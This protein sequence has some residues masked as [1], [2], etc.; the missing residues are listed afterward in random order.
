MQKKHPGTRAWYA[1]KNPPPPELVSQ[2]E[3]ADESQLLYDQI[4]HDMEG[5]YVDIVKSVYNEMDT[6]KRNPSDF[7][8]WTPEDGNETFLKVIFDFAS[9]DLRERVQILQQLGNFKFRSMDGPDEKKAKIAAIFVE[10]DEEDYATNLGN[11]AKRLGAIWTPKENSL[12]Y[13]IIYQPAQVGR[14][15]ADR[16]NPTNETPFKLIGHPFADIHTSIL[17]PLAE[18]KTVAYSRDSEIHIVMDVREILEAWDQDSEVTGGCEQFNLLETLLLHEIVELLLSETDPNMP[19]LYAHII[20]S[21]FERYL[22]DTLLNVAV[23]DFFLTWPQPTSQELEEEHRIQMQQQ[24]AEINAL[25]GEDEMPEDED[26][27]DIDDLPI[28]DATPLP[29]KKKKKKLVKKKVAKKKGLK[30][31]SPPQ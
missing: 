17:K 13:F 11:Q 1:G 31:K 12:L 16:L 25:L 14:V 3:E 2:V 29:K 27:D 26:E 9:P 23:E 30:N 8:T 6:L 5:E 18:T 7:R 22:K 10:S 15:L 20:A 21:T 19:P 28:D 4:N 24:M